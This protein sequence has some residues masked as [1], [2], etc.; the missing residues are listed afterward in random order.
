[1]TLAELITSPTV[2]YYPLLAKEY[3]LTVDANLLLCFL[4]GQ[5]RDWET[6]DSE[7]AT[8]FTGLNLKRVIKARRLLV[9]R[10]LIEIAQA[11]EQVNWRIK[12]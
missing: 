12:R 10:G 5:G 9:T 2:I 3:D 7:L 11:S 4:M 6:F 8:R 1:M